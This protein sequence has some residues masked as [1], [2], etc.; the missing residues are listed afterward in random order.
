MTNQIATCCTVLILRIPTNEISTIRIVCRGTGC[1]KVLE[2]PV[3]V[4]GAD[5]I[6]RKCK[7]CGKDWM[8]H[9]VKDI[10]FPV[11]DLIMALRRLKEI[12]SSLQI[13]FSI[14]SE[15]GK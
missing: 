12:E 7:F 10:R 13:E 6:G 2:V 3:D 1:G 8:V 5:E 15:D 4:M 11:L 9:E 14:P